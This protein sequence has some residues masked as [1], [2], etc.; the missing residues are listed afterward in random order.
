MVSES[1]PA[2][3]SLSEKLEALARRLEAVEK[4]NRALRTEIEKY[5]EQ[6]QRDAATIE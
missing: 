5:R 1:V 6:K 3:E 2:P 4:E